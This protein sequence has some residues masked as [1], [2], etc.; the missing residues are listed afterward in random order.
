M[1]FPDFCDGL[2]WQTPSASSVNERDCS[3]E[4]A[5]VATAR[6]MVLM[7]QKPR[8]RPASPRQ[9]FRALQP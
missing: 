6:S 8:W 5:A 2:F 9:Q 4:E 1:A 7:A 3:S